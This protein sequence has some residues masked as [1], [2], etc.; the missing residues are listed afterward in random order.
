M[1]NKLPFRHRKLIFVITV[2]AFLAS[3]ESNNNTE[4]TLAKTNND[5]LVLEPVHEKPNTSSQSNEDKT[6]LKNVVKE[7]LQNENLQPFIDEL[8]DHR[9][10]Q[11]S[12]Y[13]S[14]N[15]GDGMRSESYLDLC[16]GGSFF[17]HSSSTISIGENISQDNNDESGTWRVYRSGENIM[18]RFK[19]QNGTE[20]EGPV[21][22]EGG[23]L[24]INGERFYHIAKG[25]KFGPQN[26][27]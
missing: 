4:S 16:G 23:K 21:V 20:R 10:M 26:C 22:L 27:N 9:L 24:F 12:K 25:E 6:K 14:G 2:F 15:N 17:S 8:A 13:N 18:I 1:K 7:D 19:L 5:T 11:F 3:C